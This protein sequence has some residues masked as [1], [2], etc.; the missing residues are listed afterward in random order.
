MGVGMYVSQLPHTQLGKLGSIFCAG[1]Q[2]SPARL[3]LVSHNSD[4][5]IKHPSLASFP[6]LSHSPIRLSVL[7]EIPDKVFVLT[8]LSQP[9]R[10]PTKDTSVCLTP[11]A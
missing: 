10:N 7:S 11:R 1:S 3:E 9:L 2:N 4:L 5:S 8:F 6:L